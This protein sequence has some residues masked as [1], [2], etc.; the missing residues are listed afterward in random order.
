MPLDTLNDSEFEGTLLDQN[1]NDNFGFG[2]EKTAS[3]TAPNFKGTVLGQPSSLEKELGLDLQKKE[4]VTSAKK[5]PKASKVKAAADEFENLFG[6]IKDYTE[7]DTVN[8][9]V[10]KIQ[11][12]MVFVDIAYKAE[13]IIEPEELSN[14]PSKKTDLK[15]ATVLP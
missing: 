4:E 12:G 7:G 11:N 2:T 9:T 3:E 13:G 1:K 8:G 15:S 14:D 10:T 5:T 6:V